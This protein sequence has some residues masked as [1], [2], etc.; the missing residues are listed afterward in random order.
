M[1]SF[2]KIFLASPLALIVFTVIAFFMLVGMAGSLASS[3]KP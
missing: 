3:D 2:L 1:N